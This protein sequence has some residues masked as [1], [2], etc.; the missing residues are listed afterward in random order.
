MSDKL[1]LEK[2][3]YNLDDPV[4][5]SGSPLQ[6][7]KKYK[8]D[9]VLDWL[10]KQDAFTLHR[11]VRKKFPRRSYHVS[12]FNDL[13]EADLI[14]FKYLK[15]HNDNFTFV[16]V[17]V[18]VFS[19][20]AFVEPLKSKSGDSVCTGFENV[21]KRSDGRVPITLQTDKGREF[22]NKKFR[23]FLETRN[24]RFREAPSPDVKA[25]CAER[26]IRTLK[27][28]LWRY[29]THKN[30][31]RYV[32]VLQDIVRAYNNTVHTTTKM[33][34]A[35]VTLY[36]AAKVRENVAKSLQVI[37][38]PLRPKYAVGS[39]VRIS[40]APT[41]FRKGYER[42][43]TTEIFKIVHVSKSMHP[44]L[45]YLEDSDGES[46]EGFFY[47][48]ELSP[49]KNEDDTDDLFVIDKIIRSRG[50]G[51]KKECLVRWQNYSSKYD[52]W[53]PADSIVLT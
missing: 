5:Y 3:Y 42:S 21:L 11:Q 27:T 24:I 9:N 28:R 38:R 50:K 48:E 33:Q 20:Y 52:S 22:V 32:D 25:A 2:L 1:K 43:W 19:K 34:P 12:N 35:C 45:Y 44:Y 39:F 7:P 15:K 16:L 51:D 30:T 17:I 46:I 8:N 47:Q 23:K 29:F 10:T 41:T 14:D 6:F 26:L 18:D 31:L 4:A 37:K 36:N 49:V 40:R 13:W 53:V